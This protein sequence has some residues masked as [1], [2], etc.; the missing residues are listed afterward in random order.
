MNLANRL[1]ELAR[2]KAKLEAEEEF[3][4]DFQQ[5][6]WPVRRSKIS[7]SRVGSHRP[8]HTP[9]V[10]EQEEEIEENEVDDDMDVDDDDQQ[11][12]RKR[13]GVS[14]FAFFSGCSKCKNKNKKNI[15]IIII[16]KKKTA[17]VICILL[18]G[19]PTFQNFCERH[20]FD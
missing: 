2:E 20:L 18:K 7:S 9:R 15:K 17:Q 6:D 16:I 14:L 4:D 3:E 10:V 12:S 19:A 1:D 11:I 13:G 8:S 5:I